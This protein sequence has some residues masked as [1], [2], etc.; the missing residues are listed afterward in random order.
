MRADLTDERYSTQELSKLPSHSHGI[1][2]GCCTPT[3][4]EVKGGGDDD[5][6]FVEINRNKGGIGL[7][8]YIMHDRVWPVNYPRG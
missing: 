8:N 6:F 7:N 2:T 1:L 5:A 3:S 4:W